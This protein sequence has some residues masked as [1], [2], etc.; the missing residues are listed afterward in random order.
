MAEEGGSGGAPEVCGDGT[1]TASESC[2]SCPGDCAPAGLG[3]ACTAGRGVCGRS[4]V[5]VCA[6]GGGLACDA[7]PGQPGAESCNG[8][9]DDCNGL[10]DDAIADEP[11]DTGAAGICA[12]GA[13]R[14]RKA[15][16]V[17]EPA[18]S[19]VAEKCNALDEDCDGVRDDGCPTPQLARTLAPWN[20]DAAS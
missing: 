10:V 6:E 4:G 9:D 18:R 2:S 19:P 7:V 14:C 8:L 15:E 17:Y 1:C 11:C 13:L 20:G 3:E 5:K 12:T 16:L